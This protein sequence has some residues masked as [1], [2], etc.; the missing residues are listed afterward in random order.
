MISLSAPVFDPQGSVQVTASANST[1]GDISRRIRKRQTLDGG[2]VVIDRGHSFGDSTWTI[3]VDNVSKAVSD[4]LERMLRIYQTLTLVTPQGAFI[5][6]P[7]TFS[8]KNGSASMKIE[9]I[10]A[11]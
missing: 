6:A 2:V 7:S 8:F 3:V 9:V 5:V 4:K 1:I 11:A 10:G